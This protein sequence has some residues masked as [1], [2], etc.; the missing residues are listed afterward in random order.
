MKLPSLFKKNKSH[1][2]FFC[3]K[4]DPSFDL[5]YKT[6]DGTYVVK[7]CEDCSNEMNKM[8]EIFGDE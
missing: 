4:K 1:N 5:S 6:R 7:I 2:C 8:S 3:D